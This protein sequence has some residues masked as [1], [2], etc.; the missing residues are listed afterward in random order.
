MLLLHVTVSC[1]GSVFKRVLLLLLN[2]NAKLFSGAGS[3]LQ[4]NVFDAD[5]GSHV[6]LS[7][8]LM[9]GSGQL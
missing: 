2:S 5:V 9:H 6:Q 7:K 3:N 4:L 8:M 1:F